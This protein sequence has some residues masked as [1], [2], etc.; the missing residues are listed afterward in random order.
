MGKKKYFYMDP[1]ERKWTMKDFGFD[2]GLP[3]EPLL[4]RKEIEGTFLMKN[5]KI[6]KL[7]ELS[8]HC[9]EC[10]DPLGYNDEHDSLFCPAC[11][12][13]RQDLCQDP[14]CED[15]LGRPA[16]PSNCN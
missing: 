7:H 2:W 8:T 9:E 3:D 16:K 14:N 4:K 11:D 5:G 6:L 10:L 1:N 12:E 13:W 15:C